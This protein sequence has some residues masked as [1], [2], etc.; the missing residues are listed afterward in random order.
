MKLL[1][2]LPALIAI[3]LVACAIM[4]GQAA[5]DAKGLPGVWICTSA[6]VNGK[7]LPAETAA[8]LRLT[9]TDTKYMSE[10]GAEVLFESTYTTDTS[11]TPHHINM[12]GTEGDLAG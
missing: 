3:P 12:V 7:P 9:L 4:P 8:K 11:T 2:L 6:V 1:T 5:D 10:K